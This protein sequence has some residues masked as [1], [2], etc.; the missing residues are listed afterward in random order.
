MESARAGKKRK[1][2]TPDPV[3]VEETGY[4]TRNTSKRPKLFK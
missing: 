1:Y 2:A 4:F 3:E